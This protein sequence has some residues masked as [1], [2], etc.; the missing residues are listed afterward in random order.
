VGA[1]ARKYAL[2]LIRTTPRDANYPDP[3]LHADYLLRPELVQQFCRF[4]SRF[5]HPFFV[6]DVLNVCVRVV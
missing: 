1:D 5:Y 6:F 4:D 2:D 3:K